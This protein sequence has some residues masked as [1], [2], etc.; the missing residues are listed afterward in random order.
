M[1][2]DL[3]SSRVV[4]NCTPVKN[5]PLIIHQSKN[6]L[7][8]SIVLYLNTLKHNTCSHGL[9]LQLSSVSCCTVTWGDQVTL[10]GRMTFQFYPQSCLERYVEIKEL[11]S[12]Q[13]SSYWG[14]DLLQSNDWLNFYSHRF[15]RSLNRRVCFNANS[16]LYGC[17]NQFSSRWHNSPITTILLLIQIEIKLAITQCKSA[18]LSPLLLLYECPSSDCSPLKQQI[19][20]LR[21][22]FDSSFKQ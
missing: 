19:H 13:V 22:D 4:F 2:S 11:E 17:A 16:T 8:H 21:I 18:L 12:T 6:C 14:P 10:H 15:Q 20:S 1:I 9:L 5:N 7:S 3:V